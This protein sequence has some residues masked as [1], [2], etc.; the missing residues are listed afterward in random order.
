MIIDSIIIEKITK[1]LATPPSTIIT[2][3]IYGSWAKGTQT[4]DSDLDVLMISD[5]INPKKHK[6]GREI[7]QIKECL[8]IGLP[9]DIL[10]LTTNECISNFRNHNPLFLDIA[11]EGIILI[12]RNDFLKDL[13]EETR[14]Y[15]LQKKLEKLT[16]GWKFPVLYRQATF[17]SEVSNKDFAVAMLTDG[18]RDFNIGITLIREGFYDKA[19][20]HFQQSVEKSVKAVLISFGEFKKT[21]FVGEVLIDRLR[22][23]ELEHDWKEKLSRIANVSEEIEPEVT[24]SRYPGID[25]GTLW[26]PYQEYTPEDALE[27]KEKSGEVVKVVKEFIRWWF[28]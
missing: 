19:V 23:I 5:E 8:S 26:V 21:H 3:A 7:A 12:D 28:K 4:Q 22:G 13:I 11:W 10:L 14:D 18:E 25:S 17:L 9:L 2:A 16:D 24:W 1:R 20:Y 15:I 27:I 6:R